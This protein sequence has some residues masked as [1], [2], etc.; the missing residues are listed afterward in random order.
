M[1]RNAII[2]TRVS[3]EKQ[4]T[5]GNGLKSQ[6][7]S[8][9]AYCARNNYE[10]LKVFRDEG[11]TGAI[12]NRK[13]YMDMLEYLKSIGG[14]AVLVVD[15]F[16]RIGRDVIV[17]N[18]II[19]DMLALDMQ[20][21]GPNDKFENTPEGEVFFNIKSALSQYHRKS[22]TR[23]VNSRMKARVSAGYRAVGG[24]V[25]GYKPT[26]ISGL[27]EPYQPVANCIKEILEGYA[28]G[29]FT[30]YMD[31]ARFIN[32][33]KFP[34][35][36]SKTEANQQSHFDCDYIH[37]RSDEVKVHILN[38]A[39]Y[40]AGFMQNAKF[41]VARCK[42][43]HRA[44]ISVDTMELIERRLSGRALPVYRKNVNDHFP[45]RG[46]VRCEYCNKPMMG[47][48][49]GGRDKAYGYYYCQQNVCE[50][51][52]KNARYEIVHEQF[53]YL[54]RNATPESSLLNDA[55][56]ILHEVWVE[57]ISKIDTLRSDWKSQIVNLESQIDK[58]VTELV[59]NRDK[60]IKE[61]VQ[62][63][64]TEY[65]SEK[66]TLEH[67]LNSLDANRLDFNLVLNRLVEFIK[68]PLALWKQG[69]LRRKQLVQRIV[70]PE[71]LT[72][73]IQGRKFRKPCTARVFAFLGEIQDKKAG[74]VGLAG[75]EP[76]TD[77]L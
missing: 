65:T 29:R 70:F 77:P 62:K 22:N 72:F 74:V 68:D 19:Q 47:S 34:K 69:D 24:C 54:L 23:Q 53:E 5:H 41:E 21:E 55:A 11:I 6:E 39:W 60:L 3:S 17:N 10:V 9:R 46:F 25:L 75:L 2:Y 14:N 32:A 16:S 1:K 51:K 4:V 13:A 71:G 42:G 50:L 61:I 28:S 40:Y 56:E 7:M 26:S 63:K 59:E 48:F 20:I 31:I 35:R 38:Q 36:K 18:Q 73:E 33:K 12:Y 37:L 76:A 30:N 66:V 67:K 44:I 8:C 45:L 58:Y 64:I 27:H 52:N 49:C 43:Q 15:D 57:E